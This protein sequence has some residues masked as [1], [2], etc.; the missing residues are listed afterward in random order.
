MGKYF[1]KNKLLFVLYVLAV[2]CMSI[3][4]VLFSYSMAPLFDNATYESGKMAMHAVLIFI[5]LAGCDMFFTYI[6]KIVRENL[7][8]EYLTALKSDTI[9]GILNM[10]YEGYRK[11]SPAYYISLFQRDIA[12]INEDYFDGVCGVYRVITNA[13]TSVA[14]L[15]MFNPWICIVNA[16]V[17]ALSVAVPRIFDKKIDE[18][19]EDASNKA[20]EYQSVLSDVLNGFNT[21][22]L[23]S[24]VEQIK[25][26]VQNRNISNEKSEKKRIVTNYQ[27]SYLSQIFTEV[28]YVFTLVFGVYL[29]LNGK[30]TIGGIIAVSQLAGGILVPFEELPAL[31]TGIKSV[32]SVKKK[33]MSFI[34][35]KKMAD[36]TIESKALDTD[37]RLNN[38]A[39]KYE[40][41]EVIKGVNMTFK[42]NNKYILVGES[43]SGKSTIAKAILKM[44]PIADGNIK[45]GGKDINVIDENSLYSTINYMQQEVF[46]F[47]DSIY[48]NI[49]LYKNHTKEEVDKVIDE[50]GLTSYI[51]GLPDGVN[52]KIS[53]N[54]YNLSGGEKQRI[55]IARSLLAGVKVLVLDEITSN[56]DAVLAKKIEDAVFGL[57]D[58]TVIWITHR[59]TPDTMKK[60][61]EVFVIRNGGIAEEG[62]YDSLMEKKGIF[63]SYKTI[64]D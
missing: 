15:L 17:A 33:V 5:I 20:S 7:R 12:R 59:I 1:V 3:A 53:G 42:P 47:D 41:N 11:N 45:I 34:N 62:T 55:G 52:T 32:E 40:D 30:M 49:T 63:Y 36:E 16:V 24:V 29:V 26:Y 37:I 2:P 46:L 27:Y 64:S 38:V 18:Y 13:I 31:I 50:A 60:A 28:G 19:S 22:R 21:I 44:I 6:H 61:S 54:G 43:G 4:S 57:K 10:N 9:G 35:T 58:V 51:N 14:A 8:C 56:L 23:F 48:N 25:K 39:I